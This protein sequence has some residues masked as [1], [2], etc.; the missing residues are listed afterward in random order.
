MFLLR[1]SNNNPNRVANGTAANIGSNPGNSEQQVPLFS[2]V[3]STAPPQI[4]NENRFDSVEEVYVPLKVAKK[5]IG[6]VQADMEA[7]KAEHLEIIKEL[8]RH[9]KEMEKDMQDYFLNYIAKLKRATEI[10]EKQHLAEIASIKAGTT[11]FAD[12]GEKTIFEANSTIE[13]LKENV[14]ILESEL[15]E[16]TQHRNLLQQQISVSTQLC[17]KLVQ[18][19][20]DQHET[21]EEVAGAFDLTMQ[22]CKELIDR[23]NEQ[24][25]SN[26]ELKSAMQSDHA[27]KLQTSRA[28]V[29]DVDALEVMATAIR[30]CLDKLEK[31][32]LEKLSLINKLEMER[33]DS[34][35]ATDEAAELVIYL[36]ETVV[37]IAN[38]LGLL[39]EQSLEKL[40]LLQRFQVVHNNSVSCDRVSAELLA[41]IESTISDFSVVFASIDGQVRMQT[42]TLSKTETQLQEL[43]SANAGLTSTVSRLENEIATLTSNL[44][45]TDQVL[46]TEIN[47]L[48]KVLGDLDRDY[49]ENLSHM[50]TEL[51]TFE[52]V[53]T[54]L[55]AN[56]TPK[57]VELEALLAKKEVLES[58]NSQFVEERESLV[59]LVESLQGEHASMLAERENLVAAS[60]QIA[61]EISNAH[62][63]IE[64][65]QRTK[66]SAEEEIGRLQ[67][68]N[69]KVTEEKDSFSSQ[70]KELESDVQRLTVATSDLSQETEKWQSEV[71]RLNDR[72]SMLQVEH[73]AQQ[74]D[75][76]RLKEAEAQLKESESRLKSQEAAAVNLSTEL[77][78]MVALC[79]ED[80]GNLGQDISALVDDAAL[81][82]IPQDSTK[83]VEHQVQD[84]LCVPS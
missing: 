62:E 7:M 54:N 11:V 21:S 24:N 16:I 58:E 52:K 67:D 80:C 68:E 2:T 12:L 84:C 53:L 75:L 82:A 38:H 42:E 35:Q 8:E 50:E 40:S 77:L 71:N 29:K 20:R 25:M 10:R 51:S 83:Y 55:T 74:A 63:Q 72:L 17:H 78:S 73:E 31:E 64:E 81:N 49:S 3:L 22:Q 19:L 47:K 61:S 13:T 44:S 28:L 59:S 60:A 34:T 76:L 15:D 66:Q 43:A 45:S 79:V 70:V 27:H 23:L 14:K 5:K 48:E 9:Y 37:A 36:E 30:D 46:K 32:C 39:N 69:T 65:L 33:C 1:G 56:T 6:E 18:D 4:T 41:Q 26:T 57:I